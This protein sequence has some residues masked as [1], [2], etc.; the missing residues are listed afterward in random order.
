[1]LA[2]MMM[3]LYVYFHMMIFIS[4][5]PFRHCHI[6][7]PAAFDGCFHYFSKADFDIDTPPYSDGV[8]LLPLTLSER[9]LLR[10]YAYAERWR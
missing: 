9:Q 4:P 6:D 2:F 3:L 8:T 7:T 10:H 5:P 1:M